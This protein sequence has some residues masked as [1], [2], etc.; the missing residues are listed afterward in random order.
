MKVLVA[1][2]QL[3]RPGDC[4]AILEEGF[5]SNEIKRYPDKHIYVLDNKVYSDVLGI[6][7]IEDK[8]INVIPLESVYYPRKDDTVIGIVDSIGV[9]SW[10]IDIRAPYKAILPGSDVIEGFNPIT[11]NLRNYLDTGDL[12]LAKIAVFDRT[13]DPVLTTKGKGLGKI[14]EGVVVEVKPSKVARLVGKK[15][16]MYNLLSSKSGCDITIA[17]NGY[18]LLKCKDEYVTKV[19]IEAIRL[20]ELKAHMRGL[21]EEV[22]VFLESKLG[23]GK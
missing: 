19:L 11:H 16:S 6:V 18:I 2:R 17:Q 4:L 13:R 20:I 14:L 5:I 15:G 7:Y 10:S 3:V 23:E 21:T 1:D 8:D 22:R 9:T 12:I